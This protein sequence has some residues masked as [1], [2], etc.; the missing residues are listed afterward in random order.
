MSQAGSKAASAQDAAVKA[1]VLP[2]GAGLVFTGELEEG[3][4]TT[5]PKGA[6]L[7]LERE[8][9]LAL[10]ERGLVEIQ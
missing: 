5:H 7:T 1:R 10:E 8:T 9:A 4:F 3:V 2:K 6:V